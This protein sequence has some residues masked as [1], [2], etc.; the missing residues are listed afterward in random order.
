MIHQV[1]IHHMGSP[2]CT[3]YK[4]YNLLIPHITSSAQTLDSVRETL[5]FL[6]KFLTTITSLYYCLPE[7]NSLTEAISFTCLS[8]LWS[9]IQSSV[10]DLAGKSSYKYAKYFNIK[11]DEIVSAVTRLENVKKAIEETEAANEIVTLSRIAPQ[12]QLDRKTDYSKNRIPR[13]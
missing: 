2:S 1:L 3:L 13:D 7:S 9:L 5:N 6:P 4:I 12:R 11:M 10:S 8:A